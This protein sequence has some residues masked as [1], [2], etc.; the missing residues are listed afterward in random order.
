MGVPKRRRSK[1]AKRQ[2]RAH[3][4]VKAP[5]LVR[6]AQ[7]HELILPHHVC[8]KCGYYKGREVLAK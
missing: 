1:Q 4:K 7:C 3:W 6:C 2:R 8:S 5:V